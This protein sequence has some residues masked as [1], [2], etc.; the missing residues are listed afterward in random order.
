MALLDDFVTLR[1]LPD[2]TA[3]WGHYEEGA[4]GS[5]AIDNAML[6]ETVGGLTSSNGG[7]SYVQLVTKN[8]NSY[9]FP[10]GYA[11]SYL[12]SGTWS[13]AFN[14]LSFWVKTSA[15]YARRPDGGA[16]IE[17]GTYI[18]NHNDPD[19]GNQ[20]RHFYHQIDPNLY[21]NRWTLV[22][23]NQHPQHEVGTS[24]NPGDNPTKATVNY[25][26]GLTRWYWDMIYGGGVNSQLWFDNFTFSTVLGEPDDKVSSITTTYSGTGYEVTWAALPNQVTVYNVSYST[27][28][29]KVAGF[30]SGTSG[31]TVQNSGNDYTGVFWKSPPMIETGLCVAIQPQGQAAFAEVCA[32]KF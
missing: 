19:Q 28:S 25:Y 3:M 1:S 24:G 17:L 11:Q 26:D 31:G 4:P 23:L 20:G 29:M 7:G 27:S 13:P 22:V 21:A 15:T 10:G 5:V 30:A 12:K 14:R 9:S 2:G 16:F 6:K 8:N 32:P 18:R